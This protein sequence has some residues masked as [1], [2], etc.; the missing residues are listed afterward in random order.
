MGHALH[1]S[2]FIVCN[3]GNAVH[4]RTVNICHRVCALPTGESPQLHWRI[5]NAAPET[6]K[7]Q[8][9]HLPPV[10]HSFLKK[11]THC[12]SEINGTRA[13]YRD[14]NQLGEAP[15]LPLWQ[16][17]Q[18]L[19]THNLESYSEQ[20]SPQPD[21]SKFSTRNVF[22]TQCCQWHCGAQKFCSMEQN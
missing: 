4:K 17:P 10:K 21:G 6:V 20:A 8:R 18:W 19:R 2:L 22:T 14:K 7:L 5:L 16:I 11:T 3:G 12:P 15:F 1:T 9:G 13:E